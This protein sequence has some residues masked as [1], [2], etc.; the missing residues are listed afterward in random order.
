MK[1]PKQAL[2]DREL[3]RKR[4]ERRIAIMGTKGKIKQDNRR[5]TARWTDKAQTV[6]TIKRVGEYKKAQAKKK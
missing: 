3:A 5:L 6:E 4:A 1:S 2:K